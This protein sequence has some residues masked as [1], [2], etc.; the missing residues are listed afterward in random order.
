MTNEAGERVKWRAHFNQL[1]SRPI[2]ETEFPEIAKRMFD[3][4]LIAL[5]T[6]DGL[7]WFSGRYR[8]SAKVV[9]DMWGLSEHQFKRFNR[10]VY[11]P[12]AFMDF[13]GEDSIDD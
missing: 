12:D 13:T 10:W 7:R 2:P 5:L 8:V 11:M 9:R 6:N 1:I 4:G 3:D